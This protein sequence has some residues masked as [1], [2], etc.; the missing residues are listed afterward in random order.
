MFKIITD[1]FHNHVKPIFNTEPEFDDVPDMTGMGWGMDHLIN[2][3]GENTV[4]PSVGDVVAVLD[5]CSMGVS[6][7]RDTRYRVIG[8]G[9]YPNSVLGQAADGTE[10]TLYPHYMRRHT[11]LPRFWFLFD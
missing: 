4:L 10:K 8:P 9:K 3:L 6:V 7:R 5:S 11:I 2:M 1:W